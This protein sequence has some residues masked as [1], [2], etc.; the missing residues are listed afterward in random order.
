MEAKNH[1][2]Y[3]LFEDLNPAGLEPVE[4][5]SGMPDHAREMRVKDREER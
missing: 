2:E 1:L 5:K 3:L 4:V